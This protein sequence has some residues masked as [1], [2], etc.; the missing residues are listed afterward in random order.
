MPKKKNGLYKIASLFMGF[1]M[2][3]SAAFAQ[4]TITGKVI[5]NANKQPL[6]GATVQVKGSLVATQTDSSGFFSIKVPKNNAVI[7]IT[8]VGFQ[9]IE[10]SVGGKTDLG[11]ISLLL[12][13]ST[14]NEVFVTGYT[15]QRKRDITGS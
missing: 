11:E 14:L 1:L 7:E 4:R 2:L 10:I 15:S 12:T 8:S 13:N 9:L 3:S 6:S 5:S